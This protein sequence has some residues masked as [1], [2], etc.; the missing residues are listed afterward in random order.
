MQINKRREELTEDEIVE[1]YD[2]YVEWGYHKGEE[3]F[4]FEDWY[5]DTFGNES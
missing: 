3:P 4:G 1:I 2:N 5:Q